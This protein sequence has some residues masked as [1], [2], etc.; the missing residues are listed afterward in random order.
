M[1]GSPA[2]FVLAPVASRVVAPELIKWIIPPAARPV[3]SLPVTRFT[4]SGLQYVRT[5]ENICPQPVNNL[6]NNIATAL[7]ASFSVATTYASRIPFQSNVLHIK[8]SVK[9]PFGFQSVHWRWPWKPAAIALWPIASSKKPISRS[10][11][12]P[13]IKSRTMRVIFTT[14]SQSASL[15]ARSFCFSGRFLS[16]PSFTLHHCS[17]QAMAF[18]YSSWS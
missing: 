16:Q 9:S 14:N 18:S 8:A 7:Q 11:G 2:A 6:P 10:F 15:P 4:A 5:S 1:Q 12:L 3:N 17:V 13:F